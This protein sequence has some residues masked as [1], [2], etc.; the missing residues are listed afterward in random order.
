MNSKTRWNFNPFDP[1][2]PLKPH[3][4]FQQQDLPRSQSLNELQQK[5]RQ[6]VKMI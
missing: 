6:P 4:N 1:I 5:Q 3:G 2:Q